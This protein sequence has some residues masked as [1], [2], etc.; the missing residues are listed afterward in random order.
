MA[1]PLNKPQQPS[2]YNERVLRDMEY[3]HK[4]DADE[5]ITAWTVIWTLFAF[6]MITVG[7]IWYASNSSRE[8]GAAADGLLVA[9]TWY[10]MVIPVVA[11]SGFVGYRLRLRAARKRAAH[12]RQAEFMGSR[13]SG[14][15]GTMSGELTDEEKERLRTLERRRE[16]VA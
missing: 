12:L 3:E 7:L 9:T 16:D 10:W 15:S 2:S 5:R 4:R 13:G 6:K 1:V 8:D 14:E 11:L